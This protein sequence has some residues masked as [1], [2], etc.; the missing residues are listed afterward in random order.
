M[1]ICK[2]PDGTPEIYGPVLQGEGKTQGLP[3]IFVRLFNCNI[4]CKWCDSFY[5]W[6]HKGNKSLHDYARPVE[7][8]DYL[9]E[10]TE[11]D[12]ADY[13]KGIT[14]KTGIKN[15]V[16]T[17]GEPLLQQKSI[18]DVMKKLFWHDV[19]NDWHFEI[20]TNGTIMPDSDVLAHLNQINC[21][22]KLKSSGVS[23]G[24][25][26]KPLVINTLYNHAVTYKNG[27]I[28]FK[29]VIRQQNFDEDIAE[30]KEWQKQNN[31]DSK[32]IYLMPEGI[33][34]EQII[35]T[36]KLLEEKCPNGYIINTRLHVLLNGNK[37]AV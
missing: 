26:N 16:F 4:N 2:M 27:N 6:Y 10:M 13:I 22:P 33:D 23:E 7:R 18:I 24:M 31:I 20:E 5:T 11:Q 29:F 14:S 35:E 25:R 36:T 15:V 17:G 21:S 34:R 3:V 32:Y 28:C 30:V 19:V 37:R 1:K 8:K 9:L 12:V